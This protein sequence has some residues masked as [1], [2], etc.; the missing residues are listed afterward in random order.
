MSTIIT[1]TA[2]DWLAALTFIAPSIKG[3]PMSPE[4]ACARI[5]PVTGRLDGTDYE[6]RAEAHLAEFEGEGAPFLAHYRGLVDAIKLSTKGDRSVLVKVSP[7]TGKEQS[8]VVEAAGWSLNLE[9][10]DVDEYPRMDPAK[11]THKL[12]VMGRDLKAATIRAGTAVSLDDTLSILT[13]IQF[14]HEG[15]ALTLL[16][17]DRYRLAMDSAPTLKRTRSRFEFILKAKVAGEV[18]NRTVAGKAVTISILNGDKV[19]FDLPG[20]TL[21][22]LLVDGD[23]PK[24]RKLF[25]LDAT[26]VF[27]VERK[28]LLAAARVAHGLSERNTP[29]SLDFTS[30][31]VVLE[32]SAGLF[33]SSVSPK[34]VGSFVGSEYAAFLTAFNPTYLVPAL[35]TLAG[36]KVRFS[37]TEPGK[38][39]LVTEAEG[40]DHRHLLMPVRL[41]SRVQL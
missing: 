20:G 27:E 41:P 24:V 13:G 5:S 6:V 34:I 28:P 31:G 7:G 12:Q 29:A 35:A 1:A 14:V 11:T 39:V 26:G 30:D 8:V 15:G 18:A 33:D 9:S 38:A 4:L 16:A 37:Y 40:G 19:R 25:E 3:R 32:F 23:Y 21:E 10:V 36:D 22:S 2:K 17:T